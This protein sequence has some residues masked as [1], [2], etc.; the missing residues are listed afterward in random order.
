MKHTISGYITWTQ[1]GVD[2]KSPVV[3][4]TMYKP[5]A[6]YSPNTVIVREHAI[7]VEVADNFDPRAGLIAGLEEQKRIVRA[8]FAKQVR[9]IDSRIQQLLA[10]ENTVEAEA[11]HG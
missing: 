2:D 3:G 7:E 4:F 1:Y 5:S 9:D 10:I 6:E 11:A 8:A